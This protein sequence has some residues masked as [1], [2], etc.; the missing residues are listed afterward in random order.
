[1]FL[2]LYLIIK[3]YDEYFLFLFAKSSV[4]RLHNKIGKMLKKN[5]ERGFIDSFEK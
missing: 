1:M 5:L 4:L 2:S 3:K